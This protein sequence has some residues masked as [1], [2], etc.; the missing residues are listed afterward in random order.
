MRQNSPWRKTGHA[1]DEIQAGADRDPAT[2]NILVRFP[3][4]LVNAFAGKVAF[5]T[6]GYAREHKLRKLQIS[7]ATIGFEG[8]VIS[9]GF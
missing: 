2:A 6:S 4:S 3:S 7:N 1:H 9:L 8:Q 5:Y